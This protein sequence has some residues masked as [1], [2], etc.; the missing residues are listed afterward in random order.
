[1]REAPCSAG[2][3]ARRLAKK[4]GARLPSRS[5]VE[6]CRLSGSVHRIEENVGFPNPKGRDRQ[7]ARGASEP[8]GLQVARARDRASRRERAGSEGRGA[9]GARAGPSRSQRRGMECRHR[10]CPRL[11]VAPAREA[12]PSCGRLFASNC[13]PKARVHEAKADH[14]EPRKRVH[15]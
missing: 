15:R 12:R 1:M 14:Q 3:R 10:P 6:V 13:R 5:Y 2:S 9:P 7:P 8:S 4:T 11:S